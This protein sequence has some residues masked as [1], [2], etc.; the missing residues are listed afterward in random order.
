MGL[1]IQTG[2]MARNWGR[3]F[4]HVLI[5]CNLLVKGKKKKIDIQKNNC[6]SIKVQKE[7]KKMTKHKLFSKKIRI[8]N[9]N[10]QEV[11]T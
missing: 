7:E 9:E 5:T 11:E 3:H 4:S 10:E 1:E 6:Q 8:K 2:F